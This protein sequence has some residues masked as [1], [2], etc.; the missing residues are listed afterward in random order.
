MV[1]LRGRTLPKDPSEEELARN[2]TLSEADRAQVRRCRGDGRDLDR[3]AVGRQEEPLTIAAPRSAVASQGVHYLNSMIT[4]S[5]ARLSPGFA[6]TV[7]TTPSHGTAFDIVGKGVA[8]TGALES[9]VRLAAQLAN[10]K[11][12]EV[13]YAHH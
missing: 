12:R 7:F 5:T 3:L 6:L 2:W 11:T 1:N 4:S 9:A 8:K 13:S 10:V